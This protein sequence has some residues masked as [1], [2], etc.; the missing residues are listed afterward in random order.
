MSKKKI[1]VL[2]YANPDSYPPTVNAVHLLAEH[3]DVVLMGRNQDPPHG[4][5]PSNV[6]VHRL[7]EYT[8]MQERVQASTRAKLWEYINFIAQARRLLQDVSLIYAYDAF[9]FTAAYLCR[10]LLHPSVS[11]IYHN[12]D[13]NEHLFPIS[14]LTGWVQRGERKWAHE[15]ALV[16]FPV[17]ERALFFKKV[18]NLKEPPIIV[19]NFP[20][21]SFFKASKDWDS[22][23]HERFKKS[24]ILLQGAIS[25]QNSLLD[26]IKSL[27]FTN[28]AIRLKLIGPIQ[29]KE[30][31]LMTNFA[32]Q[33]NVNDR[34]EYFKPIPYSELRSHTW[35]A[36]IG[37]CLYK[38]VSINHQTMATASNKI[39][40]YAACG[41]P[42]I[43][44]DF[45]NHREHFAS[46][47][48]VHFA[49][50]DNPQSIASAVQNIFSDFENYKAM[51]LAARQAFEEKFN[52]EA[53]F[54]PLLL[55]I[56]RL[57][58]SKNE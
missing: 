29:E 28:N 39:Y 5:Y 31:H 55:D 45:P 50:P 37:V 15:A 8:S 14:S 44:S 43:V 16:V 57:V 27:T 32:N 12:H 46:E 33:N 41:L 53:A 20:R 54:E 1:G 34:V 48:W 24:Q 6:R 38:K 21:K 11:L 49:D 35:N 52:Y 23:M 26:I 7:G 58:M 47:S 51:C 56:K 25:V 42:I 2:I 36:S 3:F 40:E 17:Q 30:Q 10:R 18:T 4:E 19:P 22:L 9:A 13:L